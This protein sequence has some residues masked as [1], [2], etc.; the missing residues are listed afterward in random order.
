MPLFGLKLVIG[1]AGLAGLGLAARHRLIRQ[2]DPEFHAAKVTQW[3]VF[4]GGALAM[5][6]FMELTQDGLPWYAR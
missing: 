5:L 1:L 2:D 4:A 3:A 6:I